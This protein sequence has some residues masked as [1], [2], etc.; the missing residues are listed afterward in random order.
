[1]PI[2]I[3][4]YLSSASHVKTFIKFYQV[5]EDLTKAFDK[6]L[7]HRRYVK[8]ASYQNQ[9]DL[10]SSIIY[11][12]KKEIKVIKT[13]RGWGSRMGWGRNLRAVAHGV[14]A[15]HGWEADTCGHLPIYSTNLLRWLSAPLTVNR[16]QITH[17]QNIYHNHHHLL[18]SF[19]S[20]LFFFFFFFGRGSA[21]SIFPVLVLRWG[22]V[23]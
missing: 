1:M 6:Y 21:P 18:L 8:C 3:A 14:S 12:K 22:P 13:P 2:L 9:G 11:F 16:G 10:L 5:F 19:F 23:I 4:K 15:A 17:K 7:N 20:F